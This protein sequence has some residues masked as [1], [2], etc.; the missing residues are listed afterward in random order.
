LAIVVNWNRREAILGLL[1]SLDKLERRPDD[2]LV[3]DNASTDGSTEAVERLFPRVHLVR[4]PR[5]LGGSG[6][7]NTGLRWGL[8]NAAFDFFWLLDNDVVVHERALEALLEL[9]QSEPRAGLIG[10]L[11][12]ELG[13]PD[14]VQEIGSKINWRTG[15]LTRLKP[16]PADRSAAELDKIVWEADY[17]ASCSLLARVVAVREVGI[18]DEGYFIYFDDIDWSVRIDK[19]G[20]KILACG[21]SRIE[22]A[23]F[24]ERSLLSGPKQAYYSYRNALFFMR[25]HCPARVRPFFFA[26]LFF[27]MQ[28]DWLQHRLTGR[29]SRARTVQLAISDF[30]RGRR[31]A[32]P[33]ELPNDSLVER[34]AGSDPPPAR[35]LRR[36]KGRLLF[37][38]ISNSP[39]VWEVIRKCREAFPNH[40]V[41]VFVGEQT[42][43][44][45][46]FQDDHVVQRRTKTFLDR[47]RMAFGALRRY[48]A[49]IQYEESGRMIWEFLFP[50]A[51][52]H[53]AQG[54]FRL[55]R[56]PGWRFWALL[57]GNL[58]APVIAGALTAV[59][60][61][62]PLPDVDYFDWRGAKKTG[63]DDAS[64]SVP[65]APRPS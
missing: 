11:I 43:G 2:I 56:N 19:A 53:D 64:P 6:G 24:H 21:A 7:F 34:G 20:W 50:Q 1:E 65:D 23:S 14:K 22:H 28:K 62:S 39:E 48:D 41:E 61:L 12:L 13:Q 5:N 60:L 49:I 52:W 9:A 51:L 46:L 59:A 17:V 4:N 54:R 16:D 33:E 63:A 18:W 10:S 57:M 27:L 26:R 30:L 47:W 8:E 44:A 36:R 58:V 25:R 31:G 38:K 42:D 45:P 37:W 15:D 55:T 29:T 32:C 35:S 3:V 40:L